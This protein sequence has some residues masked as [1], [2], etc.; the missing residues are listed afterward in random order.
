MDKNFLDNELSFDGRA[1]EQL[2]RVPTFKKK[3]HFY[4]HQRDHDSQ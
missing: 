3:G 1:K 2:Y 4:R